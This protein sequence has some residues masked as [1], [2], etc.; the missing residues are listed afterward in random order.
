VWFF[1]WEEKM[2]LSYAELEQAARLYVRQL[3]AAEAEER[4]LGRR[5]AR[6]YNPHYR[7]LDE[8]GHKPKGTPEGG[9][10]TGNGSSGGSSEPSQLSKLMGQEYVGYKGADAI[11]K[12]MQEKQGHVKNAFYHPDI[13]NIDLFWGD[14]SAGLCHII[15]R[16]KENGL[17]VTKFLADLP[18][19]IEYGKVGENE[20]SPSDRVNI[21]YKNTVVVIAYELRGDDAQA[22]LTAYKVGANK[23]S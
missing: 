12:L 16:R 7:A 22:V 9:Q 11:D 3:D 20:D 5:W 4:A 10:F 15:K 1:L 21:F 18:H 23:K 6:Q 2:A 19:A 17:N 13:G 8:Q 14:E